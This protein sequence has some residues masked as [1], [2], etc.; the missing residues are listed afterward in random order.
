M[1]CSNDVNERLQAIHNLT[2]MIS[3]DYKQESEV[4]KFLV[5]RLSDADPSVVCKTLVCVSIMI[6]N[7]GLGFFEEHE[8]PL[9]LIARVNTILQQNNQMD[10]LQHCFQLM[11]VLCSCSNFAKKLLKQEKIMKFCLN[12]ITTKSEYLVPVLLLFETLTECVPTQL[13]VQEIVSLLDDN[14]DVSI[15][16]ANILY[17]MKEYKSYSDFILKSL[18]KNLKKEPL[19]S[20]ESLA[21]VA[22]GLENNVKIWEMVPDLMNLA[23]NTEYR[24]R[25]L[26]V[27]SNALFCS[28][29]N[30]NLESY[31]DVVF[32]YARESDVESKEASLKLL[33]GIQ[34]ANYTQVSW[35]KVEF[36]L[37]LTPELK[38]SAMGLLIIIAKK[39][40]KKEITES[41][42]LDL[43]QTTDPDFITELLDSIFEIYQ[44]KFDQLNRLQ[45]IFEK[46]QKLDSKN[47]H[48][49]VALLNLN[50]F[51]HYMQHQ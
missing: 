6:E 9:K 22:C 43:E 41:I 19:L 49:C 21:N 23:E 36:L 44:D 40:Y 15:P 25:A 18:H 8:L 5:S 47:E 48:F 14:P 7:T 38:I 13:N 10:L 29:Q 28:S 32:Q 1:L 31:F 11:T 20:L 33:T 17:N 12:V 51:I 4:I 39:E 16:A 45:L 30:S 24:F 27:I 2:L 46:F 37:T 26:T 35:E 3:K 34:M 50:G 42:L